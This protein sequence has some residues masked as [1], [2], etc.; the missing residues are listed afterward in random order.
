MSAIFLFLLH[1]FWP[2]PPIVVARDTTYITAPLRPNGLPDYEK[3]ILELDRKGA[4][5]DNNAAVLL[6]QALWPCG[7]DPED[8]KMVCAELGLKEI[9]SAKAAL[10]PLY[11]DANKKR[12]ADW[13]LKKHL[14]V[15]DSDLD[16]IDPAIDHRWTSQQFPPLAEW[17][18]I[19]KRPLDL[20]VEASRRP[21]FYSPSPTLLAHEH[22]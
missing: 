10:E 20:I 16:T 21:R 17:V 5:P 11:G 6:F 15:G 1:F 18:D 4:T 2:E 12:V 13:R 19:N 22:I 3:Y 7:L 9:P 8:Y 14:S